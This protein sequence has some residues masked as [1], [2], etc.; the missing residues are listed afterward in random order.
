MHIEMYNH[1]CNAVAWSRRSNI[2]GPSKT[3]SPHTFSMYA[4]WPLHGHWLGKMCP[5]RNSD[6][7]RSGSF[8]QKLQQ[9]IHCTRQIHNCK[10]SF[11][12]P[13]YSKAKQIRNAFMGA[14]P[15]GDVTTCSLGPA[16]VAV[17]MYIEKN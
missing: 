15:R 12:D 16:R 8:V 1:T 10:M 2:E 14:L 5:G 11:Q 6:T 3:T 13:I 9:D 7:M 4:V 17:Y